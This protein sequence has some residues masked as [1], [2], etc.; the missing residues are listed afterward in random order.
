MSSG[1]ETTANTGSSRRA[2]LRPTETMLPENRGSAPGESRQ[3]C[4]PLSHIIRQPIGFLLKEV[5]SI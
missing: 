2:G 3:V 1:I 4:P 5:F